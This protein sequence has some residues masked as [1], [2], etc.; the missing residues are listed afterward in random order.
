LRS[1][2]TQI[3]TTGKKY[4][5]R[6]ASAGLKIVA[7]EQAVQASYANSHWRWESNPRLPGKPGC[8]T[9]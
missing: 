4:V 5:S 6:R 8:S 9:D 2:V 3:F 7:G 1:E